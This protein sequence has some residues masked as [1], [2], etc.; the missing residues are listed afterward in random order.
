MIPRAHQTC[1]QDRISDKHRTL[2]VRSLKK[3]QGHVSSGDRFA[4]RIHALGGC[5]TEVGELRG[6][7]MTGKIFKKYFPTQA[8]NIQGCTELSSEKK[9]SFDSHM[10]DLAPDATKQDVHAHAEGGFFFKPENQLLGRVK[11]LR[12]GERVGRLHLWLSVE[13]AAYSVIPREMFSRAKSRYIAGDTYV[14]TELAEQL[15]NVPM[16]NPI[17]WGFVFS[18]T[19]VPWDDELPEL[20]CRLGLENLEL[21]AYVRLE[22]DIPPGVKTR[23]PTAF[24]AGLN[25]FWRPGGDTF[26]REPCESKPGFPEIVAPSRLAHPNGIVFGDIKPLGTR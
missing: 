19:N 6:E 17:V 26:P 15:E 14:V 20:P 9:K 11:R 3:C 16:R 2:D 7:Q 23:R 21:D 4:C 25:P 12:R 1:K 22:L 5:D 10:G 8:G 24:D 13:A 18:S